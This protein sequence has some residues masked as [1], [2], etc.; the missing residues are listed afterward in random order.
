MSAAGHEHVVLER[1]RVGERWRSERWDSLHLLTPNWTTPCP[2]SAI[3]ARIPTVTW[4]PTPSPTTSTATQR[5]STTRSSS[6]RPSRTYRGPGLLARIGSSRTGA[7]GKRQ[8]RGR[9]RAARHTV[10]P[11]CRPRRR[12]RAGRRGVRRALPPPRP[13]AARWCPRRRSVSP[14][15]QIADELARAGRSVILSVG[16]HTRMPRR[17]R[18]MDIF[19]WLESTGRLARTIDEMP[20]ATAA[21]RKTSL[22]LAGAIA[23]NCSVRT[24]TWPCYRRMGF[25]WLDAWSGSMVAGRGSATIWAL[26]SVLPTG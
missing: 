7:P 22:Q 6:G 4:P 21:R 8:H 9:D 25:G 23:L 18:G 1:G 11:S 3:A 20:D 10:P 24:W 2:A 19:R 17:Y 16:R 12:S 13:A 26:P 5:R 15:V 14:G